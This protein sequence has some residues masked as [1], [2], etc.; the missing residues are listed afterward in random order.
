MQGKEYQCYYD[1]DGYLESH[2]PQRGFT[3][4]ALLQRLQD[5]EIGWLDWSWWKDGC[6][7]RQIIENGNFSGLT[8]YGKDLVHNPV[9]GLQVTAQ[10]SHAF[11][12]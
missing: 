7:A 5:Q 4:Q 12:S 10:R 6:A 3:Y 8:R 1:L 11:N 9:Y 2:P